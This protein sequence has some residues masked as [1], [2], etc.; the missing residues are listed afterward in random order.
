[1]GV[2]YL[3][4]ESVDAAKNEFKKVL[5]IDNSNLNASTHLIECDIFNKTEILRI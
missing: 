1:L 5:E 2:Q 3:K 4:I